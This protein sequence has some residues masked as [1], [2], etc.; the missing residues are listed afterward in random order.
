M[1]HFPDGVCT[2]YQVGAG[3]GLRSEPGLSSGGPLH[4][5]LSTDWLCRLPHSVEASYLGDNLRGSSGLQVSGLLPSSLG[6]GSITSCIITDPSNFKESEEDCQS[7]TVKR[8]CEMGAIIMAIFSKYHLLRCSKL[9]F[10]SFINVLFLECSDSV[11]GSTFTAEVRELP[12]LKLL[13]FLHSLAASPLSCLVS[14]WVLLV[15][16]LNHP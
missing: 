3:C 12:L 8:A 13:F 2:W 6:S 16:F 11:I 1:V 5:H 14:H 4:A 10:W 9:K 15:L 7:D